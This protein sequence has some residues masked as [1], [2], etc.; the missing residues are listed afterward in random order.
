VALQ[1][2]SSPELQPH[3][4][5]VFHGAEELAVFWCSGSGIRLVVFLA[6]ALMRWWRRICLDWFAL[7]LHLAS[8]DLT[9]SKES[10]GS[11]I[12]SGLMAGGVGVPLFL[13]WRAGCRRCRVLLLWL[14][15]SSSLSCQILQGF[16]CRRRPAFPFCKVADSAL[17]RTLESNGSTPG[18]AIPVVATAGDPRPGL[19][20]LLGALSGSCQG[21]GD[22]CNRPEEEED[23]RGLF[24]ICCFVKG[25]RVNCLFVLC[26]PY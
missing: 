22:L 8:F 16:R 17:M 25:L 24:V 20:A 19:S 14:V 6:G 5:D 18:V 26:F 13:G 9:P 23:L 15:A 7:E 21:D 12:P 3:L 1:R 4:C 10:S 2:I 11:W